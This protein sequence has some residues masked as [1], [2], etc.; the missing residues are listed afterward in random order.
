MGADMRMIHGMRTTWFAL[1]SAAAACGGGS[2]APQ[3]DASLPDARSPLPDT[4]SCPTSARTCT[5][6]DAPSYRACVAQ[7]G[8]N[9][10]DIVQVAGTIS[11]G[12]TD[13]CGG[14]IVSPSRPIVIVGV[15]AGSGFHRTGGYGKS[16]ID[17][18]GA[19][20]LTIADLHI[21]EEQT[22]TC[23]VALPGSCADSIFV[24]NSTGV[25]VSNVVAEWGKHIGMS[26]SQVNGLTVRGSTFRGSAVDGLWMDHVSADLDSTDVHIENNLF[27]DVH[28]NGLH[29]AA[30]GT[31]D[32]PS[33]VAGNTFQH[34][35][36]DTV[37][38]VCGPMGNQPCAGG[39]FDVE[40]YSDQVV[41]Q[42]NTIIAGRIEPHPELGTT[43][44][45]F[46]P[47]TFD[48]MNIVVVHNDIHDNSGW[49]IIADG[50]YTTAANITLTDNRLYNDRFGD[51]VFTGS[52]ESGNC[53]MASCAFTLPT[54]TLS[55]QPQSCAP[56]ACTTTLTWSTS[57]AVGVQLRSGRTVVATAASGSQAVTLAAPGIVDLY[58]GPTLLATVT[59]TAAAPPGCP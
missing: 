50:D 8:A 36:W 46:A 33:T 29:F 1:L 19:N 14:T 15:P 3:A 13:D 23:D 59:V 28:S 12:P 4:R 32:R 52:I 51:I 5:A 56:A 22:T 44:I 27:V 53:T 17:I 18:S 58:A 35:H 6:T 26:F 24:H 16:L 7:V 55:A 2:A 41:I 42:D 20:D 39:Q 40:A 25:H 9:A 31:V 45:E 48:L 47:P 34:N 11:C 57:A 49:G 37:Y 30:R 21:D 54:G 38:S 43:G 10:V